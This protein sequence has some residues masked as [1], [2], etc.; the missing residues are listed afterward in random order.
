MKTIKDVFNRIF[1][2]NIVNVDDSCDIP[3]PASGE[4]ERNETVIIKESLFNKCKDSIHE[5]CI[6]CLEPF[7]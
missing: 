2:R 7:I 5:I 3:N 4:E 1:H 6:L